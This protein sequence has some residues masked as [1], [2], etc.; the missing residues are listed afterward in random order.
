M[1]PVSPFCFIFLAAMVVISP[2]SAF[3]SPSASVIASRSSML[4][5]A[6]DDRDDQVSVNEEAP[7]NNNELSPITMGQFRFPNP[8]A[9][10]AD[11][12]QNF[13]DVV[14]DFFNKRVSNISFRDLT[15]IAS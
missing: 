8:L 4:S 2:S 15:D 9:E 12:F 11:I 7:L 6:N 5:A 14:D 1:S 13:D 10:L 3:V